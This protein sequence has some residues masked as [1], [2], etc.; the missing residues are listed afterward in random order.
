MKIG[1]KIRKIRELRDF[2]QNYMAMQL[3][4]CPSAYANIESDKTDPPW[5]RVCRIAELLNV[6]PA[7]LI[8]FDSDN[9]FS[10]QQEQADVLAV[11]TAEGAAI[12]YDK[13]RELYEVQINLLKEQVAFLRSLHHQAG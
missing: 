8:A 5:S 11:G 6:T 10:S 9:P 3:N 4:I 7:K 13:E 2:T 12:L 1:K